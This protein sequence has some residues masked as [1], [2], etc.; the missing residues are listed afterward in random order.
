MQ[1]GISN[2]SR[3]ERATAPPSQAPAGVEATPDAWRRYVRWLAGCFAALLASTLALIVAIGPYS[4]LPLSLPIERPPIDGSLRFNFTAIPRSGKFD[5]YIVGTSTIRSIDPRRLADDLGGRFANV[6]VHGSTPWEQTMMANLII[7][8]PRPLASLVIGLDAVWCAPDARAVGHHTD[9]APE[10]LYDRNPWND[11]LYLLNARALDATVR[12][13]KQQ[14]GLQTPS[15]REDGFSIDTPLET[16]YDAAKAR[17]RIWER[18]ARNNNVIARSS[19]AELPAPTTGPPLPAL[20]W[21]DATLA[22]LAPSTVRTLVIM[23][24]HQVMLP[25]PG[26][27]QAAMLAECKA[28]ILAIGR[29]RDA[30]VLDLRFGSELTKGDENYWD[31]MHLRVHAAAQLTAAIVVGQRDGRSTPISEVLH[32]QA[33]PR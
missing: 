22:R 1:R 19:A 26:T 9:P 7:D 12:R 6:A 31:N 5:S 3:C 4:P 20:R 29:A 18:N 17:R 33:S 23:P 15:I 28:K 27:P 24:P 13:I 30:T 16:S 2:E 32:H 25:A 14:L 8:Q 21:L 10:W 11:L